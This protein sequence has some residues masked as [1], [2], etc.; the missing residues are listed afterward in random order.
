MEANS[1]VRCVLVQFE[2]L[3]MI[4]HGNMDLV[5]DP[6]EMNFRFIRSTMAFDISQTFLDDTEQAEGYIRRNMTRDMAVFKLD[7]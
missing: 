6:L 2:A 4:D 1:F 3:S 7:L 5:G